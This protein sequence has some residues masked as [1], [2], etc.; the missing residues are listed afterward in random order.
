MYDE[1]KRL[2]AV[3]PEMAIPMSKLA[4]MRDLLTKTGNLTKPV[5]LD[6]FIDG[7]SRA[8]ALQIVK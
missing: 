5:D 1:V 8:M 7:K 3:D 6:T 4:W 2:S